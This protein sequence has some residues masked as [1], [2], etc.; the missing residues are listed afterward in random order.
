LR[1]PSAA[2]PG[3]QAPAW[4]DRRRRVREH[5]GAS[6][7]AVQPYAPDRERRKQ[8]GPHARAVRAR[9]RPLSVPPLGATPGVWG[10]AGGG[11]APPAGP[12]WPASRLDC[13]AQPVG[14]D[15]RGAARSATSR[16]DIW[17]MSVHLAA[18]A[19]GSTPLGGECTM[20]ARTSSTAPRQ[21]RV[22]VACAIQPQRRR[23]DRGLDEYLTR[24]RVRLPNTRVRHS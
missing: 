12:R 10:R 22:P 20:V 6:V 3:C 11:A 2:E 19:K 18:V 17:L 14:S 4:A 15:A 1:H 16:S 5:R 7:L 8:G 24:R 13:P 23:K 9:R 21:E